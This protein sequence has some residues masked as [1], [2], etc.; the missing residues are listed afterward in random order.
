VPGYSEAA[1]AV[2]P[3]LIPFAKCALAVGMDI[4]LI[5]NTRWVVYAFNREGEM[6]LIDWGVGTGPA[7]VITVMKSKRYPCAANGRC[8]RSSLRFSIP[9]TGRTKFTRRACWRRGRSSRPWAQGAGA[10]SIIYR[11]IP[12]EP[13]G[14]GR[15]DFINR[16]AMF[17]FYVDR[18]KKQKPPGL[19][20]PENVDEILV[21]EHCAERMI[22]HKRTNRVIVGG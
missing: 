8:S 17:D 6:W 20:W 21:R 9:G 19:H 5:A 13:E 7:D 11:Q 12:G 16:D 4:G 15:L 3:R 22:R 14:F 2:P 18:V 10:R 1:E